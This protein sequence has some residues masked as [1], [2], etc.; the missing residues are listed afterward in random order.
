MAEFELRMPSGPLHTSFD[1]TVAQLQIESERVYRTEIENCCA[2]DF[3][4]FLASELCSELAIY[5]FQCLQFLSLSLYYF[6]SSIMARERERERGREG[7][8]RNS[9]ISSFEKVKSCGNQTFDPTPTFGKGVERLLYTRFPLQNSPCFA[10]SRPIK[11][12]S[13]KGARN[14]GHGKTYICDSQIA[15]CSTPLVFC[16][17]S[18][19]EAI[20]N[21]LIT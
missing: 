16:F 18:C 12:G 8:E 4:D 2:A 17:V 13:R 6:P 21:F 15:C 9:T 10:K 14:I 20:R 7:R 3:P 19:V 1:L 5:T 11:R